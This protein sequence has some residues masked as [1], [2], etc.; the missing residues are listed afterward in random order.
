MENVE[1][2]ISKCLWI[3]FTLAKYMIVSLVLQGYTKRAETMVPLLPEKPQGI[4][5]IGRW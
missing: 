4:Q 3:L 1:H 5:L 2:R